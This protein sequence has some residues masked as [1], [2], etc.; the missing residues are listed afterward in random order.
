MRRLTHSDLLSDDDYPALK[1]P[2]L[3]ED[4]EEPLEQDLW[5]CSTRPPSSY[6]SDKIA[7]DKVARLDKRNRERSEIPSPHDST[8]YCHNVATIYTALEDEILVLL[9]LRQAPAK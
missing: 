6:L 7:R 2:A 3:V 8:L 9:P 5:T 1:G 4:D